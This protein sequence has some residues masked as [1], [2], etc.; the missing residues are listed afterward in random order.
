MADQ[1]MRAAVITGAKQ[2]E[3]RE[4][5]IPR[6][7]AGEIL[8]RVRACALCTVEQRLFAGIVQRYPTVPGHEY[9]GEIIEIGEGTKTPLKVGD[10]IS[11]GSSS[12]GTC[13]YC[14]IGENTRCQLGF[15]RDK[16]HEG[17]SG[18]WGLAEYKVLPLERVYKVAS[19]LPFEEAALT[20]PTACVAHAHRRMNIKMGENVLVIGAGTMGMLNMLVAK[21]SGARVM[22]SEIDE[23]RAKKA[24]GLGASAVFN[25]KDEDFVQKVKAATDGLGPEVVIIAIGNAAANKQAF[26]VLAPIG[27]M[28]FFAS[29]HPAQEFCVDPNAVHS[30]QYTITGSVSGDVQAFVVATRLLSHRILNVKPLIETTFPIEKAAQALEMAAAAD[31]CYRVVVTM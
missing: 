17:I 31:R 27:R 9:S 15:G 11:Q 24:L 1:T 30:N 22:V 7:G 12:C 28:C 23:A 5:P 18:M 26:Q 6:P 29:A 10:R 8:M 25:P 13:Y 4:F 16:P 20:E 3:V 2:V 19:D 21:V 14:R